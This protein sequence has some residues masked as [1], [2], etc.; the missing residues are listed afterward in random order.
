MLPCPS[1]SASPFARAPAARGDPPRPGHS[2]ESTGRGRLPPRAASKTA[3]SRL[4][5]S[6]VRP[7]I[8]LPGRVRRRISCTAAT[9]RSPT[10]SGALRRA[11]LGDDDVSWRKRARSDACGESSCGALCFKLKR[12][13]SRL[14]IEDGRRWLG[15]S[16]PL[17]DIRDEVGIHFFPPS[18]TLS[19]R[20]H[21]FDSVWAKRGTK[22]DAE[23]NPPC[24]APAT[25][26]RRQTL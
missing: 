16:R 19:K 22:R 1:A 4:R 25:R 7:R 26:P 3:S 9:R 10:W 12:R 13:C 6:R 20:T 21:E 24:S 14:Q 23:S 8:G 17:V 5:D 11:D 18:K 15:T 2:L